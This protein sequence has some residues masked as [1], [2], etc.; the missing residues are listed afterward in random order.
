MATAAGPSSAALRGSS[1][2]N[3]APAAV[4]Q[5]VEG[6]GELGVEFLTLYAFSQE[7]WSRP[8]TEVAALMTLLQKFLKGHDA[9]T[10]REKRAAAGHRP[11]GGTAR[12]LPAQLHQSPSTP[13]ASNTGLTLI[14]ALSYGARV[15][16]I[17]AV[18][19][20]SCARCSSGTST[21]P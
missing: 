18:K 15:E 5:S 6:C 8:R 7:N 4:R 19:S 1:A 10:P 13:T 9:R 3:R 14:L 20:R 21:R 17:D 12:R 11:A 2:T 16:M